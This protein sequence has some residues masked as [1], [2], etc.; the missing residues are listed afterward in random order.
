MQHLQASRQSPFHSIY[1]S[2][3]RRFLIRAGPFPSQTTLARSHCI[4]DSGSYVES[5]GH[6]TGALAGP[7][8]NH[9]FILARYKYYLP[10]Y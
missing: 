1:T 2:L 8:I 10:D 3:S 6:E 5:S 4:R 7:Y 9:C